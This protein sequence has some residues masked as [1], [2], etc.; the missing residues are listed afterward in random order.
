MKPIF[1]VTNLRISNSQNL[2]E[3][4]SSKGHS[5]RNISLM[6]KSFNIVKEAI[7]ELSLK[8]LKRVNVKGGNMGEEKEEVKIEVSE[9]DAVPLS[10]SWSVVSEEMAKLLELVE[11]HSGS[12]KILEI[13]FPELEKKKNYELA[14]TLRKKAKTK[15]CKPVLAYG[16]R[17]RVFLD[18]RAT[19]EDLEKGGKK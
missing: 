18:F 2:A 11:K 1:R 12:G 6:F 15:R 9:V 8:D 13:K 4:L 19:A 10:K 7:V 3:F 17:G 5:L 14:T 16:R